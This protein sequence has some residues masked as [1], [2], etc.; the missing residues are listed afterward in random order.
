MIHVFLMTFL[1]NKVH[2]LKLLYLRVVFFGCSDEGD[3]KYF[4]NKNMLALIVG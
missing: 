1:T 3:A 2:R 4:V